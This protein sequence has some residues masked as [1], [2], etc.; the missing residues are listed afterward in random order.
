MTKLLCEEL[1]TINKSPVC[2]S[3]NRKISSFSWTSTRW[4]LIPSSCLPFLRFSSL[5]ST[6]IFTSRRVE[7]FGTWFYISHNKRNKSNLKYPNPIQFWCFNL[8][9]FFRRMQS[10]KYEKTWLLGGGEI[11]MKI[12]KICFSHYKITLS[13]K[14][15]FSFDKNYGWFS[16]VFTWSSHWDNF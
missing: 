5:F 12:S 16:F 14:Y 9:K 11:W 10:W 13:L 8:R 1:T 7:N 6:S 4:I 15:P 3:S 2:Q